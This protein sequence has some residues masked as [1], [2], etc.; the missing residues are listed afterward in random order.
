MTNSY[1]CSPAPLPERL[2]VH[3][4]RVVH[5]IFHPHHQQHRLMAPIVL[6]CH[7]PDMETVTVMASPELPPGVFPPT[8]QPGYEGGGGY[9]YSGGGFGGYVGSIGVPT[10]VVSVS[11]DEP[12]TVLM[13]APVLV[14]MIVIGHLRRARRG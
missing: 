9:G 5:N 11:V 3:V 1:D 4:S 7:V 6:A 2:T 14:A 8:D 12:A 13:L 10:K